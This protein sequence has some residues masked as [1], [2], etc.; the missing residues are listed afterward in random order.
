MK[1]FLT[2]PLQL[3]KRQPKSTVAKVMLIISMFVGICIVM[4]GLVYLQ[5]NIFDGVRTYVRGEGLWA[6]S[7]KDAVLYLTHYS[8]NHKDRDF[9]RYLEATTV[10]QGDYQARQAMLATPIDMAGAKAGFIQ[11]LNDERD[12]EALI[13][14]F[15]HFKNTPYMKQA[16]SLWIQAEA[17]MQQVDQLANDM[18]GEITHYGARA[19]VLEQ[20][21]EQLIN[22]NEKLLSLEIEF[23]AVLS[24]GAR[25]VKRVSWLV[26]LCTL[27]LFIGVGIFASRQ[28]VRNIAKS[29]QLLLS[30]ESRFNSLKDSDTIGIVSWKVD[31]VI[32]DA[33][34]HFLAMIGFDNDDLVQ[35]RINWRDLTPQEFHEQDLKILTDL[36]TQGHCQQFEKLLYT[37]QGTLI[38]VMIGANLLNGSHHEGIA[39]IM[40]LSANKQ[41]EDKLRLAAT[42][43]NASTDGILITDPELKIISINDAFTEIVGFNQADLHC[44]AMS[45]LQTGHKNDETLQ[46]M[47]NILS[48]GQQWQGELL[49]TTKDGG[50]I[51][52]N[53]RIN[54]VSNQQNVLTHFVIV[55]TD[56]AER[57][58]EEDYL[59]HIAHHDALTNL[60][61]RVLFHTKL[62]QAIVHAQ[63]ANNIFAVLF[64]DLDNFK[65]VNDQYGHDVGDKL[66]QEVAQRLG[67]R[68]RQTDTITRMGGDEFVMLLENLPNAAILPQLIHKI[69]QAVCAPCYIK[70]HHID[71]GIS[72]GEA[73]Y[74]QDGLDAKSLINHADQ[75]MYQ[76]KKRSKD[77]NLH[78]VRLPYPPTNSAS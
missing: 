7:Q 9:Q 18:K 72:V 15:K 48:Q 42:V 74:P 37:K 10:M 44:D 12:T 52:L 39:Y 36:T 6:K 24:E 21:R 27:L 47:K 46:A 63:R 26:S 25:W 1:Y 5:G 45:F 77:S 11:G 56:I 8:Y 30:S 66:L 51:P 62:E 3:L 19:E 43:F 35:G 53:V 76:M 33:N 54:T 31:G 60:P 73:V 16:I 32:T 49:K 58:A 70:G 65:P 41:A 2:Y 17:Q 14:F 28:I 4:G 34:D 40:D 69:M 20:Y 55:L 38:P 13:W 67:S 61:N 50:L 29:E 71:I 23:S 57:K 59:R 78:L 75:K 68:I 22:L 64:F